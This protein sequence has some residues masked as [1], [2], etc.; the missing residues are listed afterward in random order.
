M[1]IYTR[2]LYACGRES[3]PSV[4]FLPI[5]RNGIP[6]PPYMHIQ[7][8]A[9]L[10][11]SKAS[12]GGK[13]AL[14]CRPTEHPREPSPADEDFL[15]IHDEHAVAQDRWA[16]GEGPRSC[17]SVAVGI[18]FHDCHCCGDDVSTFFLPLLVGYQQQMSTI[19]SVSAPAKA[20]PFLGKM[21]TVPS[22]PSAPSASTATRRIF[23]DS[24]KPA[25]LRQ[26][27]LYN[28]QT[29][30]NQAVRTEL[31]PDL[32]KAVYLGVKRQLSQ[33]VNHLLVQF[34]SCQVA[35]CVRLRWTKTRLE[36]IMAVYRADLSH[37]KDKE[38]ILHV[39]LPTVKVFNNWSK[40]TGE[41]LELS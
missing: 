33:Q 24:D 5:T 9:A 11:R 12:E 8:C 2:V 34:S 15:A 37:F 20:T 31:K 3:V 21:P 18:G 25:T 13:A 38:I 29:G 40:V 6:P 36:C 16:G 35:C 27:S 23:S 32:W 14:G 4:Y 41:L 17:D 19:S 39:V 1:Y 22:F 26:L 10:C 7:W 30:R 28:K